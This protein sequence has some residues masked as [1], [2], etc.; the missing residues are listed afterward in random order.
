LRVGFNFFFWK[1][2]DEEVKDFGVVNAGSDI[3][4]L[5]CASLAFF[6]EKPSSMSQFDDEDLACFSEQNWSLC[7]D[8]LD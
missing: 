1:N 4:L 6:G 3:V 7:T 2:I 5:E 8:H